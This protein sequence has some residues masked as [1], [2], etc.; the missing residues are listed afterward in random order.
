MI[1]PFKKRK[2][3][4]FRMYHSDV[5][6]YCAMVKDGFGWRPLEKGARSLGMDLDWAL[7]WP[8]EYFYETADEA[9]ENI[10]RYCEIRDVE[11]VWRGGT[12]E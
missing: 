4:R 9:G 7:T 1:W 8:S 6:G 11:L 10:N 12:V 5:D 3:E 2:V